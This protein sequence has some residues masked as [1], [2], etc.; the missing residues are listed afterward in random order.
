MTAQAID[1][2]GDKPLRGGMLVLA[3]LM[4]ASA[5]FIAVLDM[6]IANVSV[7]NIS[8]SLGISSTQG[9]W[10]ITSY[11]VAEA[12]IVPLTGWIAGRFGAVRVF[13]WAMILFGAFSA[14]CAMS[15]SLE[16]LV[17]ARICQGLSGGLLMPLSQTLLLRIFPKE[18]ANQAMGL[19]AMTTLT[20]PILGPILG[21]VICDTWSWPFIFLIN[22]PLALMCAPLISKLLGRY[23]TTKVRMPIDVVG[24]ILLV[25][26]VGALQLVLDLGKEHG[27]FESTLIIGLA[28]TAVIGFIA[29]LIWELTEKHPIVDLR[30]FRHRGFTMS[31]I[32]LSLAF[33]SMFAANVLTPLWL[34]SYMGYTSTWAGYATAWSGVLAVVAAPIAGLLLAKLDPRKLIFFGLLWIALITWLRSSVT[35]DV[36]Y[37][38][39]SIPLMLMGL[40]LPF[41]FVPLTALSLGSVNP[42]ETASAAGLQNFLRT[43]SGA[44]GTS[45]VQ[46]VW[47][48]KT[49]ANHEELA[50]LTDRQGEAMATL[51][52]SG[53][54]HDQALQYLN[55][56]VDGQAVTIATNQVMSIVA[57]CFAIAAA[58]IWLAPKPKRAVSMTEAG[59]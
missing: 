14:M 38:Q 23:E 11:A 34:Q 28:I 26:F 16:M 33:G 47:E 51:E 41:F 6:T 48:D 21:G 1:L 25:I 55:H 53:M 2:S 58:I 50:G 29:F 59:H 42:E 18:R 4:L 36:T 52:A 9:T 39:I 30:V 32:V 54:S 3:A 5:N 24:L 45:V 44:F 20:A 12:I 46:T 40:G 17:G 27:W 8:G 57:L 31:V 49:T 13:T 37:W 22:V 7:P 15:N 19:W 43:L 35:D 56:M 10:I